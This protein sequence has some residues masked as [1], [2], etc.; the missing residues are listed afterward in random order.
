M[1]IL[2]VNHYQTTK[3]HR[4][5]QILIGNCFKF[6]RNPLI[7]P[8]AHG[9]SRQLNFS[10]RHFHL[11]HLGIVQQ[12]SLQHAAKLC[13]KDFRNIHKSFSCVSCQEREKKQQQPSHLAGQRVPLDAERVE[14]HARLLSKFIVLDLSKTV[15]KQYFK[16]LLLRDMQTNSLGINSEPCIGIFSVWTSPL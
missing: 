3:I 2:R 12:P 8:P 10:C 7:F 9:T 4:N 1:N 6:S 11:L 5:Q 14:P 15:K 16:L 13:C